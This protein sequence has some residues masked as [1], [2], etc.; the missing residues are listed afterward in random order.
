M[1]SPLKVKLEVCR[2]AFWGKRKTKL[3][4][5]PESDCGISKLKMLET[6]DVTLPLNEV[7]LAVFG[8]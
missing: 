5:L 7:P 1:P 6:L 2:S 3:Q 8:D 4:V